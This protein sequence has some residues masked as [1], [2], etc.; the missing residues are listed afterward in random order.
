[1]PYLRLLV[2]GLCILLLSVAAPLFAQADVHVVQ[3]GENLFRIAQRYG[4]DVAVL[5]QINGISNTWQIYAGQ[6]LILPGATAM[7]SASEPGPAIEIAAAPV[8][9]T[10]RYHTV[11]RGEMLSQIA[12]RY[13]MTPDQLAQ[14]NNIANANLIYAGQQLIVGMEPAAAPSMNVNAA[15][16]VQAQTLTM[17]SAAIELP[18]SAPAAATTHVVQAGESLGRIAQRYNV[19][20]QALAQA[21]GIVD[22]NRVFAGQTLIIPGTP[23][24]TLDYGAIGMPA[25]PPAP[26][27]VGREILVSLSESRI[28]AY[29]NGVLLRSVLVSTGRPATPTVQGDFTIQRK[30]VAQ[31]MTGPG[32]YLPNVPYVMYFYQGYAIHGTFWHNNFG[33]PMS[34]GCVNL[35]TPEAEWFFNFADI[36]TPV[37]VQL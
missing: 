14:L 36:G 37:R 18:S 34:H 7:N 21:N 12:Q 27:G 24:T 16:P 30:Y 28:Y 22:P 17:L 29:E 35:P 5:A 32:Y 20:L 1:M 33:Q 4:T 10:P 3:P 23:V 11:A 26:R 13:G 2:V 31:T 25:A 8:E 9:M 19:S 15:A 6:T